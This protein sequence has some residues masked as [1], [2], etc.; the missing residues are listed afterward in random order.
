MKKVALILHKAHLYSFVQSLTQ[1]YLLSIYYE[2][3]V[4]QGAGNTSVNETNNQKN[5]LVA[6]ELSSVKESYTDFV[7]VFNLGT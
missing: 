7:T 3:G 6:I 1:Q 2:T 5:R 4:V